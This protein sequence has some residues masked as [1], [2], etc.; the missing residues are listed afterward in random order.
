MIFPLKKRQIKKQ[1][2][3][4]ARTHKSRYLNSWESALYQAL[5]ESIWYC[6]GGYNN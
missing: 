3:K 2:Q 5:A 4:A 1:L 6:D